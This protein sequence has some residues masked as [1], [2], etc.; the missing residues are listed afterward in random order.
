MQTWWRNTGVGRHGT[1]IT[2]H[3]VWTWRRRRRWVEFV[4]IFTDWDLQRWQKINPELAEEQRS[5][6]MKLLE[7]LQDVFTDVPG[8]TNLGKHSITLTTEESIHSK[9]YLLSHVMQKEDISEP[10]GSSDVV[11]VVIIRKPD[12]SNKVCVDCSTLNKVTVFDPKLVP[13]KVIDPFKV[14]RLINFVSE[15]R[16]SPRSCI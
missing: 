16:W 11:L 1:C 8:W 3:G 5:A 6:V 4:Y 14:K 13:Q 12:G 15:L 9:P 10:S 7:E 2:Y